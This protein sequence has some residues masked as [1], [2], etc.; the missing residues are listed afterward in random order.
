MRIATLTIIHALKDGTH[1]ARHV[2]AMDASNWD[3]AVMAARD[4]IREQHANRGPVIAA[5][6]STVEADPAGATLNKVY[7]PNEWATE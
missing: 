2:R 1:A 7:Q 3:A 5:I 6:L 4:A